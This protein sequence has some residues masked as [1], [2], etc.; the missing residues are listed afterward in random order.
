M[1]NMINVTIDGL[2]TQVEA[3]STILQ[4]AEQVGVHI[5][6]CVIWIFTKLVLKINRHPAVSVL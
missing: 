2:E 6:H 4:A 3:G 5:L 1:S